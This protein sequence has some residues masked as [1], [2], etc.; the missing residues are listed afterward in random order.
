MLVSGFPTIETPKILGIPVIP[1]SNGSAQHDAVVSLLNEWEILDKII[2]LVFDTTSS[3]T[4]RFKASA[5]AIE[6][7]LNKAVLWLACLHHVYEIHVKHVSDYFMGKRNSPSEAIFVRF[8][9]EWSEMDQDT[10]S[11]ILFDYDV[12]KE[13]QEVAFEVVEWGQDCLEKETFPRQDYREPLELTVLF[14]GGS[15]FPFSFRK[16]GRLFQ[17]V[18]Y[19]Y[20]IVLFSHGFPLTYIKELIITRGLWP[21][22]SISSRCSCCPTV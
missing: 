17:I 8:Q 22:P 3:N 13:L 18:K 20:C 1:D 5:S 21:I 15:V 4:G 14:L 11:L 7:T 2:G 12:D 19:M 10:S 6:S 16:P 9:T